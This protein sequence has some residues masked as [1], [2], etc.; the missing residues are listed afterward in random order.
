VEKKYLF[1]TRLCELIR[2]NNFKSFSDLYLNLKN[3]SSK[4]L[5]EK[6]IEYMTTHETSFFRD[7]HP[8]ETLQNIIIPEILSNK[9]KSSQL[10][11]KIRMWSA[12]CSTGQE[13]YSTAMIL[14]EEIDNNNSLNTKDIYIL[15]TDIS[16]SAIEKAKE[17][18][19]TD[20]EVKKGMREKYK[21]KY[22]KIKKNNM[23]QITDE[24]KGM[25]EFK[26]IN[27]SKIFSK[28]L[29]IFDIIFCRNTIIY[30]SKELKQK[31]IKQFY[32]LLD[33]NGILIMGASENLYNITDSFKTEYMGQTTIYRAKK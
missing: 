17:G 2:E 22:I 19:Y 1:N 26:K 5:Q 9:L 29:P 27:L 13:A 11:P 16:N 28:E 32:E 18:L 21:E 4:E 23:W 20:D 3:G 15:A 25:I 10:S 6:I 14:K 12:A 8:F 24:I 33:Y 7:T 31:I 30:F